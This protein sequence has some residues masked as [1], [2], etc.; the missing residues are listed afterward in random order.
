VCVPVFYICTRCTH[1]AFG[2]CVL[3]LERFGFV[4]Y[5]IWGDGDVGSDFERDG[6]FVL[7]WVETCWNDSVG[8]R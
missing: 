6:G 8:L 3:A 2:R 7:A 1:V 5:S 4:E